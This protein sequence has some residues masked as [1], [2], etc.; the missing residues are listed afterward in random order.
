MTSQE[1]LLTKTQLS[2]YL[3]PENEAEVLE[4]ARDVTVLKVGRS[5]GP[6]LI[7]IRLEIPLLRDS[8]KELIQGGYSVLKANT[9]YTGDDVNKTVQRFLEQLELS[10]RS[11]WSGR[12]SER[13][14]DT[15][16]RTIEKIVNAQREIYVFVAQ[17]IYLGRGPPIEANPD[18]T[19][20][21]LISD[22]STNP[23]IKTYLTP[24]EMKYV[25]SLFHL[26]S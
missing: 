21:Q 19:F 1:D 5:D 25:T 3:V 12:L 17:E 13:H 23:F 16:K 4:R 10:G 7:P 15:N 20:M 11:G 24:A 9:F 8:T 2:D 14:R 6:L 26:D 18:H 22:R